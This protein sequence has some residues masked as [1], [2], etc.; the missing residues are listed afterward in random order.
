[1]LFQGYPLPSSTST[2][3]DLSTSPAQERSDELA[4]REWFGSSSK[5]QNKNKKRDDSRDA[6]DRLRDLPEWLEEFTDNLEDTEVHAPA[7]TSQ[8]SDSERPTKLVQMSRKHSIYTHFP[9]DRNCEDY[10]SFCKWNR[11]RV[12]ILSTLTFRKTQKMRF[13]LEDENNGGSLQ[14]THWRSS[15]TSRKVWWLDNGWSQSS[16]V[17]GV[18]LEKERDRLHLKRLQNLSFPTYASQG[19][20]CPRVHSAWT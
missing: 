15:T 13:L 20:G 14:K 18:N 17:K 3:Q 8:D 2:S 16:Q 7:H 4:P 6:D 9:K 1:M 11:V 5:T 10:W 19:T 12:S